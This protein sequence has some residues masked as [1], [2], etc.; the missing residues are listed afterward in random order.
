M[1]K[2]MGKGGKKT[3]DISA[4]KLNDYLYRNDPEPHRARNTAIRKAHPE[5]KKLEGPEPLTKWVVLGTVTV[6]VTLAILCRNLSWP[7]FLLATYAISGT[8]QANLFLAIHEVT[9]NLAFSDYKK[10][11]LLAMV[12]NMPLVIP[13][14]ITFKPYHQ[15]HHKYQGDHHVDTDIPT[16]WEAKMTQ[17]PL[18]KFVWLFFQIFAYALRPCLLKPEK[19]PYGPWL[20]LNWVFCVSFDATILYNFGPYPLLYF[21]LGMMWATSFHPTAGHFL[22]EHYVGE[23]GV[24]GGAHPETFSYYGPL[25]IIAYNVGYHNEH[26]DFTTVPWTRLPKL[27][28]LAPEFYEDLPQCDSWF[29]FTIKYLFSSMNGFNRVKRASSVP[30]KD[31]KT[32]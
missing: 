23:E 1:G 26:H 3:S 31:A 4:Q 2:G 10:S 9:H 21:L 13:Y 15:D 22:A 18:G 17:N 12:A 27:R 30:G 32:K 5:V 8:F 6:H 11:R 20:A 24:D 25:N 19:V 29:G 16:Q 14:C 7:W 28:A